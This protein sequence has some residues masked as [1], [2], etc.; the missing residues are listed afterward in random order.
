MAETMTT[1]DQ[2][3][4]DA[5]IVHTLLDHLS[6]DLEAYSFGEL[7]SRIDQAAKAAADVL[8]AIADVENEAEQ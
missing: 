8:D 2:V 6:R 7:R 3:K 4:A 1:M 5:Q